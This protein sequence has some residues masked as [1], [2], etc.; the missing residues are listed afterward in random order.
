MTEDYF[1]SRGELKCVGERLKME[2]VSICSTTG[3]MWMGHVFDKMSKIERRLDADIFTD[4]KDV[5]IV[6]MSIM[7]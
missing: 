7:K 3:M 5:I 6:L 4:G 2:T 1:R